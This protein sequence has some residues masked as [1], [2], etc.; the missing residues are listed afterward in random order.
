MVCVVFS[1]TEVRWQRGVCVFGLFT[2]L[3]CDLGKGSTVCVWIEAVEQSLLKACLLLCVPS[4]FK[5]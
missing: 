1:L 3:K 5:L 2:S 4:F